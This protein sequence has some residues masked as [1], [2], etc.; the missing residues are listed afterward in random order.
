MKKEKTKNKIR[1]ECPEKSIRNPISDSFG[2]LPEEEKARSHEPNKCPGTYDLKRYKRGNKIL[3]LCS[4]CHLS[5]DIEIPNKLC[6]K[7][8]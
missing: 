3:W 2:Y 7:K 4:C 1:C 5:R 6:Q 8:K